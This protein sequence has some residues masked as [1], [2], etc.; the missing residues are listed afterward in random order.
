MNRPLGH[1]GR[2]AS[3]SPKSPPKRLLD[4]ETFCF[5]D[6]TAP[7]LSTRGIDSTCAACALGCEI[8]EVRMVFPF[9]RCLRNDQQTQL[10]SLTKLLRIIAQP[11]HIC[12]NVIPK[13]W[14]RDRLERQ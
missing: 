11:V 1:D 9:V 6:K 3:I 4:A 8:H 5:E 14:F 10:G 7:A 2:R 13:D 12:A